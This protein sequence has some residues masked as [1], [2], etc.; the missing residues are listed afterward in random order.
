MKV[1]KVGGLFAQN[2]K[3]IAWA[4]QPQ[5][6]RATLNPFEKIAYHNHRLS[7]RFYE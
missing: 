7:G 3:S 4:G 6:L 5:Y 1:L 2:G